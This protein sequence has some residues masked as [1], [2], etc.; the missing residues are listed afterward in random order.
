MRQKLVDLALNHPKIGIGQVKVPKHFVM[1]QAEMAERK[2][3]TPYLKWNQYL[4]AA[5]A[6]GI[7]KS[8]EE[9]SN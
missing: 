6:L 5:E 1:L 8:E 3:D 4:E 7:R 2:A 9:E